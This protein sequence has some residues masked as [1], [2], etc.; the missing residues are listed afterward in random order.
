LSPIEGLS[1]AGSFAYN[2]AE[3][4]DYLSGCYVGQTPAGGC[5]LTPSGSGAFLEQDLSGERLHNAPEIVAKAG[6]QYFMSFD[7]GL[8][9]DVAVNAFYSDEYYANPRQS[10]Q[11]L[12]DDYVKLNASVRLLGANDRWQ[13]AFTGRNLTDE[14]TFSRSGP[15]T[16]T[17]GGTGTDAG[18]LADRS[19][20]VS[21]GREYFFEFTYRPQIGR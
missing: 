1:L 3:F 13:V 8:S 15:V 19:G 6:V 7:N 12:Q 14:F 17:G 10:P 20:V 4:N 9:L 18:V 5:N 21:H 11:D 2:D 16:F